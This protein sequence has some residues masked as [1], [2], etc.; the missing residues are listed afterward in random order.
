MGTYARLCK[1]CQASR[2]THGMP[3][4]KSVITQNFIAG[5]QPEIITH[6]CPIC[7]HS[8]TETDNFD[9]AG[10]IYNSGIAQGPTA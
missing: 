6:T 10:G 2:G 7:G 1:E 8:E 9:Q 3:F 5:T 4:M